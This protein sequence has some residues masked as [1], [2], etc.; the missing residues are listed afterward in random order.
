M[1]TLWSFIVIVSGTM[2]ASPLETAERGFLG[3]DVETSTQM[4][5]ESE[6]ACDTGRTLLIRAQTQIIQTLKDGKVDVS[7]CVPIEFIVE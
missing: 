3:A 6:A 2:P 7:E 4:Y 5:F 1:E